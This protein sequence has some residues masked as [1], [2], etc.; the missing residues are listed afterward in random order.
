VRK[1]LQ[2]GRY[3]HYKGGKYEVIGIARHSETL[4]ELVIY[5]HLHG[6]RDLWVRPLK[7][8]LEMIEIDDKRVPRFKFIGNLAYPN[9]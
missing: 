8:F 9:Q 3:Q 1:K 7:M 5:R 2:L 6:K 4:E